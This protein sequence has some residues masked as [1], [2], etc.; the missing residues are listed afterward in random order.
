MF[1]NRIF[2]IPF[3][4]LLACTLAMLSVS[5]ARAGPVAGAEFPLTQPDGTTFMAQQWGDEWNNGVEDS[6]GYSIELLPDG[7]WV[8]STLQSDGTLAP[9]LAGGEP[10]RVGIDAPAG[11]D[12]H[13]RPADLR[14]NPHSS[15]PVLPEGP[16]ATEYTYQGSQPVLVILVEYTNSLHTYTADSIAGQWFGATNSIK[17]YYSE[18]SYG[19]LTLVPVTESYGTAND[20]V[21]GWVNIGATHPTPELTGAANQEITRQAISMANS[22]VNYATYDTNGDG[23]ISS[24]ELHI[25]VVVAGYEKSW[26]DTSPHVWAHNWHLYDASLPNYGFVYYDG[27]WLGDYSHDGFYSQ[28]GEKHG[29]HQATIGQSAHELGHDLSWPDLYDVSGDSAGVGHWSI[30][31]SGS[32]NPD[33]GSVNAGT[34]PAHP[35][36]WLKWY[37]GWLMPAAING[38]KNNIALPAVETTP[39]AFLLRL[40]TNEVDWEF[41]HYSGT[42]EYFL[43]ENRQYTGFDAELDGCG[44]LIWHIDET[45]TYTNDANN[46]RT[47]PL[48]DLEQADGVDH[49]YSYTNRGDAN[50]PYPGVTFHNLSFSSVTI[51]NSNLYSGS[52]SGV[53]IN[54]V[55]NGCA[56]TMYANLTAPTFTQANKAYLPMVKNP[57]T[58]WVNIMTEDFEGSFPSAGWTVFDNYNYPSNIY[59]PARRTYRP[60]QGSGSLWLVGGGSLGSA[61]PSYGNYPN[62]VDAWAVYG[63]FSTVGITA[64]QLKFTFFSRSINGDYLCAYLSDDYSTFNGYCFTGDW[65]GWYAFTEDLSGTFCGGGVWSCLNKANVWVGFAYVSDSTSY[66]LEGGLV[67]NIVLR[68]C[69]GS[70]C[71]VDALSSPPA[72]GD[73]QGIDP[74]ARMWRLLDPF[75]PPVITTGQWVR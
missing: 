59:M 66:T 69:T 32:W 15:V 75:N 62:N 5:I 44:L 35:D 70:N 13:L 10:L 49:L 29:A 60:Y 11:L 16:A 53:T 61:L 68:L 19:K 55:T 74:L 26:S 18:A 2:I 14:P 37:Q 27:K 12:L 50:D 58:D 71:P 9:A 73:F 25:F 39:R 30:M 21:V 51:P 47:R 56:D 24:N 4:S 63:P 52:A 34:S 54:L 33:D 72:A 38:T 42:G 64:G 67:D 45:R 23:Y 22:Y 36:A 43:I 46:D 40:N 8:Y 57:S 6:A 31:G 28:V 1:R 20:G 17:A 48:V 41:W 7:W 65:G 3:A